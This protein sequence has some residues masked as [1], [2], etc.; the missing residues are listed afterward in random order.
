MVRRRRRIKRGALKGLKSKTGKSKDTGRTKPKVTGASA[1]GDPRIPVA[2]PVATIVREKEPEPRE[3]PEG[4]YRKAIITTI[5]MAVVVA[6]IIIL[7]PPLHFRHLLSTIQKGTDTDRKWAAMQIADYGKEA[8][9]PLVKLMETGDDITGRYA[10]MALARL[11][12]LKESLALIQSKRPQTRVNALRV[13]ARVENGAAKQAVIDALAD[14]VPDVRRVACEWIGLSEMRE[15]FDPL[16]KLIQD[17]NARVREKAAIALGKISG[18][19]K[20][21]ILVEQAATS[22]DS[23]VRTALVEILTSDAF[24]ARAADILR[25]MESRC[26]TA[27]KPAGMTYA[28]LATRI[29][30]P[31]GENIVMMLLKHDDAEVRA[32]AVEGVV[33]LDIRKT[34]P[35]LVNMVL[36]D[37]EKPCMASAKGLIEF[38]ARGHEDA[39]A[40][41]LESHDEFRRY[42]ALQVLATTA[43][44]TLIKPAMNLL[45]D[46]SDRVRRAAHAALLDAVENKYG[47]RPKVDPSKVSWENWFRKI[48]KEIEKLQAI[49]AKIADIR[50]LITAKTGY[51]RAHALCLEA[52][53]ALNALTTEL[54]F[55]PK[56]SIENKLTRL[57][58]MR[59]QA[60]KMQTLRTQ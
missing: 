26:E 4:F 20:L 1:A 34:T 25:Y 13:L 44:S 31:G 8:I 37:S 38:A 11:A 2:V 14:T 33:D 30:G 19:E 5:I 29:G 3:L 21:P 60:F 22:E 43:R 28:R 23:R 10:A 41:A 24:S 32:A 18:P 57:R 7:Y 12:A 58:Q 40:I 53:E 56:Q 15:A 39:L 16:L 52:E 50:Q 36:S 48:D 9:P 42:W 49:D 17:T 54:V 35:S 55:T 46:G 45:S 27:T 59:Y 6:G 51:K 47:L